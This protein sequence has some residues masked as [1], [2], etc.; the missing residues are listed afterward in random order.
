ME[1]DLYRIDRDSVA[2]AGELFVDSVW[3]CFVLE[4]TI[5]SVKIHG[6]TAIPFGRYKVIITMSPHFGRPLPLLVDVPGFDG[7]R[8]HPGNT[9]ADTEGCLLVGQE[10]EQDHLSNSKAAFDA[11][12]PKISGALGRG[13]DVWIT[14][15]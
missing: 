4:D 1:L 5:R 14:V 10:M 3:E 12:Y 11:L 7:I 8:I 13:D 15:Q 2:T 6:E 9:S